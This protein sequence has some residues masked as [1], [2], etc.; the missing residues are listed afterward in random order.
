M[1]NLTGVSTS[2]SHIL[3][4]DQEDQRLMQGIQKYGND[5][6]KVAG[7][8]HQLRTVEEC[9]SRYNEF[10]RKNYSIHSIQVGS[11]TPIKVLSVSNRTTI[12]FKSQINHEKSN[13][14]NDLPYT[15]AKTDQGLSKSQKRKSDGDLPSQGHL[16]SQNNE[17]IK[18][19]K[20]E[21]RIVHFQEIG[22]VPLPALVQQEMT[23][24]S[25]IN[26]KQESVLLNPPI[27]LTID[28][29]SCE[30]KTCFTQQDYADYLIYL[31]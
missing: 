31:E 6:E 22:I 24:S 15:A 25:S 12:Q 11:S 27:P 21:K 5:W 18:K 17:C 28:S 2:Q 9:E 23:G 20:I 7:C 30:Y 29:L 16:F 19:E 3:W 8:F 1:L 14:L 13:S 4:S 10:W 26:M